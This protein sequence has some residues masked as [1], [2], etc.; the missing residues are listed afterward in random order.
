MRHLAKLILF[1]MLLTPLATNAHPEDASSIKSSAAH[2]ETVTNHKTTRTQTNSSRDGDFWAAIE[3][4][5]LEEADRF[6]NEWAS[7]PHDHGPRLIRAEQA[8]RGDIISIVLLYSNCA[9]GK[10]EGSECP[11]RVDIRILAPD[12]ST[13]GEFLDQSLAQGQTTTSKSLQLSPSEVRIRFE[14]ED[15]LGIYRIEAKIRDP[16]RGSAINL[17]TRVE[18]K[19]DAAAQK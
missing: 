15:A 7:T 12:G 2:T 1:G 13:Y 5:S 16:K 11:N 17:S 6:I 9:A 19:A 4:L 14:T 3:V 10:P 18:L 8:R